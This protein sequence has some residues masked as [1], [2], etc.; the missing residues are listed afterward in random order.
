MPK[1]IK[2]D[3]NSK[4]E[5]SSEFSQDDKIENNEENENLIMIQI[6]NQLPMNLQQK[7]AM[8]HI[9]QTPIAK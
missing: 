3:Y 5:K 2:L 8:I 4:P 6:Q 7:I 9:K 1:E